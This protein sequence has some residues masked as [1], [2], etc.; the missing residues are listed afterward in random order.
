MTPGITNTENKIMRQILVEAKP[1]SSKISVE[2]VSDSVYKVR[3]TA[4]PV[5]GKANAQLV[6]VLAEHFGVAKSQVEIKAG[7]TAKTKVV[8]IYG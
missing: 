2:H 6:K 5:E 8:I 1:N 7:K 3:L 4:S